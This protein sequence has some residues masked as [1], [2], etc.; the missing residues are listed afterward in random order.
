MSVEAWRGGINMMLYGI[1]FITDLDET[2]A[3][4]TA[5]AIVEYRGFGQGPRFF[6]DA[7]QD[8][9]A[10]DAVIQTAEWAEP[11]YGREDLNHSE[12][13]VRRF[14]AL[15]AEDLLRRQPWPPR[16]DPR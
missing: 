15:V 5:D 10:T 2:K 9:L 14:L 16:I 3:A 4:I 1:Q 12:E 8:A 13:D 7:I 11:P 6:L